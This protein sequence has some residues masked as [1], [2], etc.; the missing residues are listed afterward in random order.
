MF[1]YQIISNNYNQKRYKLNFLKAEVQCWTLSENGTMISVHTP[2]NSLWRK[3]V[4][5]DKSI[6]KSLDLFLFKCKIYKRFC[7]LLS[8]CRLL[9][10]NLKSTTKTNLWKN[11]MCI[12]VHKFYYATGTS[13][14]LVVILYKWT[15]YVQFHITSWM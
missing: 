5:M 14:N 13:P 10:N 11:T 12:I 2:H 8:Y 15:S 4:T 1:S 3:V 9:L 7:I 6:L